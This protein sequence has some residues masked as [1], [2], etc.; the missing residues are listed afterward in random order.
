MG[1]EKY[2][3]ATID[4][5]KKHLLLKVSK[6]IKVGMAVEHLHRLKFRLGNG[7]H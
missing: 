3:N 6:A 1:P 7:W 2:V 4:F 5:L